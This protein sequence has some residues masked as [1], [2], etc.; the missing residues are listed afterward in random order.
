MKTEK[1]REKQKNRKIKGGIRK[2]KVRL[3]IY[4]NQVR[5]FSF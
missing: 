3:I 5:W 4:W 2:M 1:R